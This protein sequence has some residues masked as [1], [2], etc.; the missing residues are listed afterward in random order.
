M[1][2]SLYEHLYTVYSSLYMNY[3]IFQYYLKTVIMVTVCD[4]LWSTR[5]IL[6]LNCHNLFYVLLEFIN[7]QYFKCRLFTFYNMS[8]R[9]VILHNNYNRIEIDFNDCINTQALVARTYHP[10]FLTF[11][12][13]I[14]QRWNNKE[15]KKFYWK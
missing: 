7:I 4:L 10:L 9:D 5:Y 14:Y 3:F 15:M 11:C 6:Y 12:L 8:Y 2:S 13:Q 1:S